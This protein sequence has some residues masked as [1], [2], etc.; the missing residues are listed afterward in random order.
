MAAHKQVTLLLLMLVWQISS[1]ILSFLVVLMVTE[2]VT[3][4]PCQKVVFVHRQVCVESGQKV[5][6]AGVILV[7]G[8]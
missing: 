3:F 2:P 8:S 1:V 4:L 6:D 5:I 7:A